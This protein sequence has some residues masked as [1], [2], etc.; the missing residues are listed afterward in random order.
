ML[1][2]FQYCGKAPATK[3]LAY[4]LTC[5]S[6]LFYFESRSLLT[7]SNKGSRLLPRIRHKSSKIGSAGTFVYECTRALT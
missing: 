4:F 6:G 7:H 5:G 1:Y 3:D 2:D